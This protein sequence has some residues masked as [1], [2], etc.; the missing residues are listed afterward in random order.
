M[1]PRQ[2]QLALP[3]PKPTAA[4]RRVWI[5][6]RLAGYHLRQTAR[7]AKR[8][9]LAERRKRRES[10]EAA[11]RPTPVQLRIPVQ[12]EETPGPAWR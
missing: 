2:L 4:E 1:K 6:D 9:T 5:R 3:L 11:W 12:A 8:R 7:E 10:G